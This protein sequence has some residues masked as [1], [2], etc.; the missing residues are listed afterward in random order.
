MQFHSE[1]DAARKHQ[2]NNPGR[3]VTTIQRE[4]M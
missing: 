1:L 3:G 4:I 2:I